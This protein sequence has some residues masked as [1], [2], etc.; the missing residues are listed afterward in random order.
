MVMEEIPDPEPPGVLTALNGLFAAVRSKFTQKNWQR[1]PLKMSLGVVLAIAAVADTIYECH[2]RYFLE[3]ELADRRPEAHNTTRFM[4][5]LALAKLEVAPSHSLE[6]SK[7]EFEKRYGDSAR[8]LLCSGCLLTAELIGAELEA[9]NATGQ[10]DPT[11]LLH[12]TKDAI[13]TACESL[14][15]ALI[16]IDGEGDK[17]T[18]ASFE[19]VATESLTGVELRRSDMAK[20]GVH[21]LCRVLLADAQVD[22]LELMIRHRVPRS[23]VRGAM[24]SVN[25]ERWLCAKQSR[26]CRNS[27]IIDDDEDAEGEL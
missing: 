12:V 4:E 1:N 14:P 5:Q 11:A 25:W 9:R 16:V 22:M 2:R 19:E 17:K 6:Q 24:P 21:R 13:V 20:M 8:S 7:A 23:R 27:E 3:S 10:P 18:S 26:L 15:P